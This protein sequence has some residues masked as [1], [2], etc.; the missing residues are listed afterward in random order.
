[1]DIGGNTT[2]I[3]QFSQVL[4]SH[5]AQ[6]NP[7]ARRLSESSNGTDEFGFGFG[8]NN[9]TALPPD[10]D[11]LPH[12]NVQPRYRAINGAIGAGLCYTLSSIAFMVFSVPI[13]AMVARLP[14][15]RQC[16]KLIGRHCA[17]VVLMVVIVATHPHALLC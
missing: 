2:R 4:L 9:L 17:C 14:Q 1:M 3:S 11:N 16:Y 12:L 6:S 10:L 13:G 8:H 7:N 5:E 15:T